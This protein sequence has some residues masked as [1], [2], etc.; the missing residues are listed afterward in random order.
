MGINNKTPYANDEVYPFKYNIAFYNEAD[1]YECR[2]PLKDKH[3]SIADNYDIAQKRFNSLLSRLKK[4][5]EILQD[6]NNVI[7]H[8][9]NAGI[10]EELC[11]I[12]KSNAGNVYYDLHRKVFTLISK[13][14][15]FEFFMT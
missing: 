13:Q 11:K 14:K 12:D 7:Q 3:S 4:N 9:L 15:N 5:P 10:I 6:Y 2:L 1:K 8:Q